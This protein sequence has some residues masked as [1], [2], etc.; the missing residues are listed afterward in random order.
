MGASWI[1]QGW[2]DYSYL[3]WN[4]LVQAISVVLNSDL[5][6]VD[7]CCAHDGMS[8]GIE[9][10]IVCFADDFSQNESCSPIGGIFGEVSS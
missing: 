3:F 6:G 4:R 8:L 5:G 10:E 2:T 9:V 1:P 7:I